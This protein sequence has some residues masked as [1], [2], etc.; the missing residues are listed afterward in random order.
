MYGSGT[1]AEDGAVR[2]P[3]HATGDF[4]L[5]FDPWRQ[6]DRRLTLQLT[7]QNIS[8]DRYQIAKE[9]QEMPIQYAQGRTVAGRLRFH[10]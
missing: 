2:L 6:D 10:F 7:L 9:S 5:G 3:Q 1:A 4:S 8:N